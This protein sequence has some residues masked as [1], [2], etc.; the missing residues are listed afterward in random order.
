MGKEILLIESRY[1]YTTGI[2]WEPI[3]PPSSEKRDPRNGRTGA[4][5]DTSFYSS[6]THAKAEKKIPIPHASNTRLVAITH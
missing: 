5:A 1:V 6:T 2:G 4:D 3:W